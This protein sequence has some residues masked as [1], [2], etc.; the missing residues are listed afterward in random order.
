MCN[1]K[2]LSSIILARTELTDQCASILER[3]VEFVPKLQHLDVSWNHLGPSAATALAK[4]LNPGKP[5]LDALASSQNDLLLG[6]SAA[7][8]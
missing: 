6:G 7:T 3:L 8:R 5:C 1:T 4:G 2:A